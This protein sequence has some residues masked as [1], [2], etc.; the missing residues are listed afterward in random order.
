MKTV[1][2]RLSEAFKALP[3]T[4]VRHGLDYH[5]TATS[6][7]SAALENNEDVPDLVLQCSTAVSRGH[8]CLFNRL[9]QRCHAHILKESTAKHLSSTVINIDTN[10]HIF[11]KGSHN[12]LQQLLT[13]MLCFCMSWPACAIVIMLLLVAISYRLQAFMLQ[14]LRTNG[15][16]LTPLQMPSKEHRQT[17]FLDVNVI[18]PR[19][20]L[21]WRRQP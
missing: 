4:Q 10:L 9:G 16:F 21:K 8:L 15:Q 14:I 1:C 12:I 5:F 7:N 11:Q 20:G 3:S 6:P 2:L 17:M 18:E 13:A 19:T